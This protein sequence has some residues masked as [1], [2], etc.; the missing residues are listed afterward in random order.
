LKSLNRFERYA[1]SML[2]GMAREMG[3]YNPN[4]PVI[5]ADPVRFLKF[6][7][8]I[9]DVALTVRLMRR[10]MMDVV[11]IQSDIVHAIGRSEDLIVGK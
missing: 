6:C 4:A 11:D 2:L 3:T 5:E 10:Q 8:R 1:D 7:A 9:E